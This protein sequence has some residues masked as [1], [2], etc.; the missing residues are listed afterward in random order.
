MGGCQLK[1]ERI[2]KMSLQDGQ[3]VKLRL[4][5]VVYDV[6]SHIVTE[7]RRIV[8]PYSNTGVKAPEQAEHEDLT[9]KVVVLRKERDETKAYA[10]EIE[11]R[12]AKAHAKI[13]ELTADGP[14]Q[15]VEDNPPQ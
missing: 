7:C 13:D 3:N 12:L 6:P 5:G 11:D 8:D 4:Q 9:E 15:P 2:S 1:N 14:G 10:A